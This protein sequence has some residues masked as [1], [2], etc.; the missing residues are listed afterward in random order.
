MAEA[1]IPRN[2][3]ADILRLIAELRPPPNV[4]SEVRPD[5]GRLDIF[6]CSAVRGTPRRPPKTCDHGS[7]L[8]RTPDWHKIIGGYLGNAE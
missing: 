2:S 5:G 7:A 8:P 3:L 6:W 1:A 4:V